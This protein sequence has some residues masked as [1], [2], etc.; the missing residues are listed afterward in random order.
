M[1][2]ARDSQFGSAVEEPAETCGCQC[3]NQLLHEAADFFMVSLFPVHEQDVSDCSQWDV[4]MDFHAALRGGLSCRF[5]VDLAFWWIH[6]FVLMD[7]GI[8]L[9]GNQWW[10]LQ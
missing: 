2:T 5:K 4:I 3:P 1:E 10:D 8:G 7:Q 9:S 6:G